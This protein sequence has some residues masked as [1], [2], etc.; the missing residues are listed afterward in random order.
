[1]PAGSPNAFERA[2]VK[3]N[4]FGGEPVLKNRRD[5]RD[6]RRQSR[7]GRNLHFPEMIFAKAKVTWSTHC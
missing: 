1:M 5:T 4:C 7:E 3:R 2:S 6:I